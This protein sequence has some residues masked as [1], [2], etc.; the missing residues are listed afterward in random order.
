M[1]Q[2]FLMVSEG[3]ESYVATKYPN[4][5]TDPFAAQNH[6]RHDDLAI[7]RTSQNQEVP[8]RCIELL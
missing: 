8:M 3:K 5:L 2:E 6:V 1:S 7:S 4:I